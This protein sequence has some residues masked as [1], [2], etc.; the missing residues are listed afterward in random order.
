MQ[1]PTNSEV[2]TMSDQIVAQCMDCGH[3]LQ[4]STKSEHPRGIKC[5]ECGGPT[6][7]YISRMLSPEDLAKYGP[8]VPPK[9]IRSYAPRTPTLQ[10]KVAERLKLEEQKHAVVEKEPIEIKE[11]L[12]VET[13][14]KNGTPVRVFV[15]NK[16][17]V[18]KGIVAG[19]SLGKMERE[20]DMNV[21]TLSYHMGKWGWKGMKPDQAQ[22]LLDE[23]LIDAPQPRG[24]EAINAAHQEEMVKIDPP[25]EVKKEADPVVLEEPIKEE[26]VVIQPEPEAAAPV[27]APAPEP[28][29]ETKEFIDRRRPVTPDAEL[30]T[31]K[32]IFH[33]EAP[34]V[35]KEFTRTF[36]I[37]TS[38]DQGDVE[39]ELAAI[40]GYVQSMRGNK[41]FQLELYLGEVKVG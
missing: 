5:T 35:V 15:P 14:P 2:T 6:S 37:K 34:A 4:L 12:S 1:L 31:T 9:T 13:T 28:I 33:Y 39:E 10:Q 11:E 25:V 22:R 18:L 3:K 36:T 24:L 41:E 8:V 17:D 23:M 30:I 19:K 16:V 29:V 40:L 27:I 38:G 26:P 20:W 21:N 7:Q 32:P